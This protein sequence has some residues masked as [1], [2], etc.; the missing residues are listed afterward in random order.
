MAG[1]AGRADQPAGSWPAIRDHLLYALI[2]AAYCLPFIAERDLFYRDESRYG[3]VVKEMIAS[4]S[5]F[6]LTLGGDFYSDK[7]PLFFALIRL[8]TE[9]SGT[10]APSVFFAI[11]ALTAFFFVAGS[12]AFLRAA[13][14]DRRTVR[15]ANL[16]LLGVPWIAVHIQVVRMD[17]LFSGL[18]LFAIAAYARGMW[19]DAAN[20]LPLLGGLLAGLA[21]MV[22]GPF[23]VA[24]P[25]LSLIAFAGATRDLRV[26]LRRDMLASLLPML[27]PVLAWFAILYSNFGTDAFDL[28]FNEQIVDRVAEGRDSSRPFHLYPLWIAF[29][30][31]PWLLLAPL[32]LVKRFWSLVFAGEARND[33]TAPQPGLRL[34][35]A[36]LFATAL[37]LGAV[38][39]KNIHYLLPLVPALL[40][41]VAIAYR[42]L[43]EKA[44]ALLDWFY[45]L[46]AIG[47]LAG[48]PAAL[49]ALGFASEGDRA[50]LFAVIDPQTLRHAAAAFALCAIP[51]AIGGRLRGSARLLAGVA[52]VAVMLF[53]FKAILL[54]DIDRVM[55]PRHLAERFEPV[56]PKG[57]PVL[58]YGIYPGSLSYHLDYPLTYVDGAEGLVAVLSSSDPRYIVTS[59][60][61][62]ERT[63]GLREGFTIVAE[64]RLES[65]AMVLLERS[66]SR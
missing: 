37:T 32:F 38:A 8:A 36:C 24:I 48:P 33:W 46:L 56:I 11:V 4:D 64:N 13:G 12:D 19:R 59:R 1:A 10:I 39:Q 26:L 57:S 3:G 43:D 23:G 47:A 7:P 20:L 30:L 28:I 50:E 60:G 25:L 35:L 18:I 53:A 55:S 15:S 41:L 51:L 65:L 5:W 27:L 17:L 61:R 49:W 63:A 34:V 22:K 16:I 44:P 21:V 54:P 58:V 31:L 42:R 40:V 52:S 45:V 6:T 2:V 66:P 9:I 62:F 14:F 29:T